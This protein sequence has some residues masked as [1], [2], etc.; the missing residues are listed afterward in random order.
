MALVPPIERAAAAP[1]ELRLALVLIDP[2]GRES[3]ALTLDATQA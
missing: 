2:A 1:P 3:A